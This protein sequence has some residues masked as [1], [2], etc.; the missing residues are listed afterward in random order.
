MT[1]RKK[2]V[3]IF[4]TAL[5]P[6]TFLFCIELGLRWCEYGVDLSLFG[7]QDIFGKK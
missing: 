7:R 1:S 3:F 2:L 6:F 4:I 5:I